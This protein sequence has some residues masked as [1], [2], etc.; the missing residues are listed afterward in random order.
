MIEQVHCSCLDLFASGTNGKEIANRRSEC[1]GSFHIISL[2]C[3][4][5]EIAVEKLDGKFHHRTQGKRTV[6]DG[7]DQTGGGLGGGEG[8]MTAQG[9]TGSSSQPT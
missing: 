3:V 9:R 2:Q 5:D 4:H 6:V 1:S 8:D 7:G